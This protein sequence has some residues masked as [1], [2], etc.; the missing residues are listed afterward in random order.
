M[1]SQL[2]VDKIRH[3]N[4]T[5]A[6]TF[7]TS[8]NTNLQ[9]DLKFGSTA[10][11]K[12][13]A[14]NNI[15][16]ESG[17]TITLTTNSAVIEGSSS[18]NL[19]RITQTG[20]GNALV[21][22]DSANP[23]STPFVVNSSGNVGIGEVSTDSKLQVGTAQ[24]DPSLARTTAAIIVRSDTGSTTGD[25]EYSGAITFGK[26]DSSR[27]FGSIAG[28]QIG[29]DIDGGGLA[30]FTKNGTSTND[31]VSE[32]MRIDSNGNVGIGT[33]SPLEFFTLKKSTNV[34]QRFH[35]SN[36]S[37]NGDTLAGIDVYA[38]L[39]GARH[40]AKIDFVVNGT[41][42][43]DTVPGK[44]LFS[45]TP[46]GSSQTPIE[47]MSIDSSGALIL[48]G[49]TAQKA[50]G[51]TWSNPSDQRLKSNISD[52]PK[53]TAELMQVRVREWEY[54]G[55]GGTVAGTKGLGVVADEIMTVLPNTVDNYEAK[56][57]VDDEETT[58]IKKFDATE[59]TWLLVKTTQEQQTLIESQQSQ[60]DALTAK[61]QEQDLT[62]ASLISRI[63]ALETN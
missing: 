33:N 54:N 58:Q 42:Q 5:D 7:D 40:A 32:R 16:S 46:A 60:I 38:E 25:G 36:N 52:Y 53:G 59:I 63:E 11:I 29:S 6:L 45:T 10:A 30:F 1:P 3:T 9:K 35:S 56:L 4:G 61:T 47:R 48:T 44:I 18:G 55:K 27:P 43:F 49:S 34:R 28:V 2:D 50:T 12:N 20:S 31:I 41:A 51:T 22:E 13:S 19:V 57:N 23:D 24:F 26:I 62:I 8:G 14:G 15:L 39:G 17:G 37:A 21:V